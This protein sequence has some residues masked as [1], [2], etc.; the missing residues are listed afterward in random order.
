MATQE[1]IN[2]SKSFGGTGQLTPEQQAAVDKA[3]LAFSPVSPTSPENTSMKDLG[4]VLSPEDR[5]AMD[6]SEAE[7]L[8]GGY[9]TKDASGNY[10]RGAEPTE[11]GARTKATNLF[12]A[13]VDALNAEK[14]AA[15][16]RLSEYYKPIAEQRLGAQRALLASSGMLGQVSGQ[17]QKT[18]LEKA[19]ASELDTAIAGSDAQ[20]NAKIASLFTNIRQEASKIYDEQLKAYSGKANDLITFLGN[21]TKLR[22]EGINNSVKQ[23]LA[24][25]I[26]LEKDTSALDGIIQG[27]KDS[28]I[29]I[30]KQ[31]VLSAYKTAKTTADAETAKAQ[32]EQMKLRG[33]MTKPIEVG[34]YIYKQDANG[35]WVNSGVK[36]EKGS[37]GGSGSTSTGST[38]RS[39]LATQGRNAISNLLNIA[40]SDPGIFGRTAALP[41]PLAA[42]S[43]AFRNYSAQIDFLKGN[44][45]PSALAAMREASKTGGAIGAVSNTEGAWLAA[46]LGALD[47]TQSPEAV[48]NSLREID[49]SLKRW[50]DAVSG[51]VNTQNNVNNEQD[52]SV[53]YNGKTYTFKDEA[54]LNGF[55][56]NFN[57]K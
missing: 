12:Q 53:D 28:G 26:D 9:Y 37:G 15:R 5:Q 13:E 46:S 2:L 18:K 49:A 14:A 3:R 11:E 31:G 29:S 36:Y 38:Y 35:N 20:Y 40:E 27:F 1:E 23:A 22:D 52:F 30:T 56:R 4:I 45:I 42:R 6:I 7:L 34:G 16:Q 33:E 54:S 47:M 17:T 39:E 55:K 51:Q 10:I 43:D 32:A 44:I 24:L 25:G 41:I 8:R 21:R 48:K 19:N 50:Q 57:I